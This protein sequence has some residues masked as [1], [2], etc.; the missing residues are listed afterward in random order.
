MRS[1][2]VIT[3]V[4]WVALLP[5]LA[6][7]PLGAATR[8]TTQAQL[9][10]LR[11]RIAAMARQNSLDAHAR[12]QLTT[13]LRSAELSLSQARAV[14]ERTA[15]AYAAHSARRAA[16]AM[17]RAAEVR[18]LA[19]ARG[20]LSDELRAAYLLGRQGTLKLLL[21]QK[22][23]LD[24]ARLLT[25]YRYFSRAGADHIARI[26]DQ[27]RQLDALDADLAQQQSALADLQRT[28]QTQLQQLGHARDQRRVV[29]ASLTSRTRTREQRLSQLEEQQ[30]DLARLLQQLRRA[31]RVGPPSAQSPADLASAFGRRQGTL[32]W[33]VAGQVRS[34]FGQS[35]G[36]GLTWDG[37]VIATRLDAPVHAVAAGRVV[38]ADWLPGLG[39]LVIIDHG[40]GYLSLYGHN[41]RLFKAAGQ[42]VAAGEVI[43]AAG[44][45]GGRAQPQ[46]YFEI[47]RAGRPIDPR[48]WFQ[49]SSP[50]G[51]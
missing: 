45:T 41:D 37:I 19:A 51:A 6:T 47:R 27:V 44:D 43:S 46:L 21:D 29:L 16:L 2:H 31:R 20:Q 14:L 34:Q 17:L 48:P 18:S 15:R 4:L 7:A 12:E 1:R 9:R 22:D 25:Y 50:P 36:D 13:Q 33:P 30:A 8:Q 40:D 10:A 32:T 26:Q 23:P 5:A 42:Q 49:A 3:A 24:S 38:Y 28:Q 11:G 39:L 35:R